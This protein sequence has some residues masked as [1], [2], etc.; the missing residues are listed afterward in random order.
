MYVSNYQCCLILNGNLAMS[1][2]YILKF[3]LFF[4]P[5]DVERTRTEYRR[6]TC[7]S[8]N[9]IGREGIKQDHF[10]S[11]TELSDQILTQLVHLGIITFPTN[12]L[13]G[14]THKPC[15]YEFMIIIHILSITICVSEILILIFLFGNF[16][17]SRAK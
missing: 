16:K 13:I 8:L 17:A 4:A 5:K 10:A 2:H 12:K 1:Y 14:Q 15:N 6:L 9:L 11:N 3:L 7:K